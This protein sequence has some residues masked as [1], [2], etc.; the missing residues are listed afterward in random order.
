MGGL[1]FRTTLLRSCYGHPLVCAYVMQ[2]KESLA[3]LLHALVEWAT[4]CTNPHPHET[5]DDQ[6][7]MQGRTVPA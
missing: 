6:Q 4:S 5:A 7:L 3:V 1:A 2:A